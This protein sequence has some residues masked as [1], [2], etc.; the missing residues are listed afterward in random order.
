MLN[1]CLDLRVHEQLMLIRIYRNNRK[2]IFMSWAM[3]KNVR[4]LWKNGVKSSS[5]NNN[6]ALA[7]DR[8][9]FCKYAGGL[10]YDR[11]QTRVQ[12]LKH[13]QM[14]LT[15]YERK[16]AIENRTGKTHC[17]NYDA[18]DRLVWSK[19]LFEGVTDEENENHRKYQ[20]SIQKIL[21][22][23]KTSIIDS[24]FVVRFF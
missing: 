13:K 16:H 18:R 24:E 22:K 8:A 12:M 6:H 10:V 1:Q 3:K 5:C 7:D 4:W 9:C 15:R 21:I 2:K 19:K 23:R 17:K 11:I 20:I 14:I